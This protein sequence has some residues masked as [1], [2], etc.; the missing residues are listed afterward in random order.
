MIFRR[1]LLTLGFAAALATAVDTHNLRAVFRSGDAVSGWE[2]TACTSIVSNIAKSGRD[3]NT[4]KIL[5]YFAKGSIAAKLKCLIAEETEKEAVKNMAADGIQLLEKWASN[6]PPELLTPIK[7][8]VTK[9]GQG[10]TGND[11]AKAVIDQLKGN[12]VRDAIYAACDTVR[13]RAHTAPPP[14]KSSYTTSCPIPPSQPAFLFR[15][16]RRALLSPLPR[17]AQ[18]ERNNSKR[19]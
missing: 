4:M 13:T 8:V 18:N 7:A 9:A 12:V 11:L 5:V 19:L 15:E 17:R 10:K 2:K 1:L 14:N 3:I 16:R 6:I